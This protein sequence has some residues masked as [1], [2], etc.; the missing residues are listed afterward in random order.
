VYLE[1]IKGATAKIWTTIPKRFGFSDLKSA[2]YQMPCGSFQLSG[3]IIAGMTLSKLLSSLVTIV[4]LGYVPG[5]VGLVGIM[6]ILLE[7]QVNLAA[8]A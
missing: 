2:L 4:F 8:C 6:T 3:R 5:M 1:I 7:H